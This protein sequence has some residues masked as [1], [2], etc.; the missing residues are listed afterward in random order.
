MPRLF[1]TLCAIISAVYK[2]TSGESGFDVISLL[3]GLE[4]AKQHMQALMVHINTF[5]S[6]KYTWFVFPTLFS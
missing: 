1:Q 3:M 5:L 4:Q 2:K 6:G